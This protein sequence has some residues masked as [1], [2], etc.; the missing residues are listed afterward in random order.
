MALEDFP[1]SFNPA[2]VLSPADGSPAESVAVILTATSS[3]QDT[4]AL[5]VADMQGT[6][7]GDLT[8]SPLGILPAYRTTVPQPYVRA[9]GPVA[10][11]MTA[12]E[13]MDAIDTAEQAVADANNA[14]AQAIAAANAAAT[15]VQQAN[16]LV[17]GGG[18][19]LE[20]HRHLV[21]DLLDATTFGRALIKQESAAT[22]RAAL[23]SA[24][25]DHTHEG[26]SNSGDLAAVASTGSYLDLKDK[27]SIPIASQLATSAQGAKA[28]TALQPGDVPAILTLTAFW[29][30]GQSRYEDVT[31]AAITSVSAGTAVILFGGTVAEREAQ[32]W[33]PTRWAHVPEALKP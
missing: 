20:Q 7:L 13:R 27:P 14:V 1:F 31:G 4:T 33:L 18:G 5:D 16:D 8:T 17:A 26:G 10:L 9:G 19:E 30:A 2:V 12:Q 3:E 32:S 6:P 28:D 24:A 15:A 29:D 23:Q 21:G 25:E 22:A 11:R